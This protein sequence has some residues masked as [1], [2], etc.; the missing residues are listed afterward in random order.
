[1]LANFDGS[2]AEIQ[3]QRFCDLLWYERDLGIWLDVS[4]MA[5]GQA[6]LDELAPRFDQAFTAM[7][8]LELLRKLKGEL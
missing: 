8:A 4:R 3:W 2:N 5:I 7:A 1:M 6:D